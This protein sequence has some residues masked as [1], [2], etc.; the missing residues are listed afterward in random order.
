[1]LELAIDTLPE[2]RLYRFRA[3]D[4]EKIERSARVFTDHELY[5][6]S[7]TQLN[8]PWESK[9]HIGLGDLDDPEYRTKYAEYAVQMMSSGGQQV[10]PAE[11]RNWLQNHTQEKAEELVLQLRGLYH[12]DLEAYRIC[13]FSDNALHP[14]LWSH[15]ADS[16][17]GFCLEFDASTDIFGHAMK[18]A[19]QTEYP[20]IEFTES[21]DDENLKRSVLTKAKFWAYEREYRLVSIEPGEPLTLP[22]VDHIFQFPPSLLTGVIFGCQMPQADMDL[23]K[24]WS[25]GRAAEIQFRRMVK[26]DTSFAL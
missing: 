7:P 9:P 16:H 24:E 8:D 1:M 22:I 11:V 10:D 5:F 25:G 18:V 12:K 3:L 21:D 20:V 26:S 23:I 17:R 13:S 6:A 15:Y 2:K 19:Y 14:L 4:R